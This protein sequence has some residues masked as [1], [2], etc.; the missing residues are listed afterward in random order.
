L[1]IHTKKEQGRALYLFPENN[2]R[3]RVLSR[4]IVLRPSAGWE[5]EPHSACSWLGR[6]GNVVLCFPQVNRRLIVRPHRHFTLDW[7][8]SRVLYTHAQLAGE[9]ASR[10]D[11]AAA[12]TY[13]LPT[14][15]HSF[16]RLSILDA[17]VLEANVTRSRFVPCNFD[18]VVLEI[19][20]LWSQPSHIPSQSI[21]IHQLTYIHTQTTVLPPLAATLPLTYTFQ[22]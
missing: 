2:G 3:A 6:H 17:S 21:P 1:A 16:T 20:R 9:L 15:L 13:L 5:L 8:S 14:V 12:Q 4:A 11:L 10:L 18:F 22:S 7:L 19:H